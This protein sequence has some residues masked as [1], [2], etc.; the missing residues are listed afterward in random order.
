[1]TK[2]EFYNKIYH[3]IIDQLPTNSGTRWI[4]RDTYKDFRK[5]GFGIRHSILLTDT[6]MHDMYNKGLR[7]GPYKPMLQ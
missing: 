7:Y 5:L 3:H 2:R 6:M 1:M 4:V